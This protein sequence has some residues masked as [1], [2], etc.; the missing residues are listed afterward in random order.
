MSE[1]LDDCKKKVD[2]ILGQKKLTYSVEQLE[3]QISR[4]LHRL[5]LV[6]TDQNQNK[7][8]FKYLLIRNP[9]TEMIFENELKILSEI[10]DQPST[11][12]L[13]NEV[14]DSGLT[15]D[16]WM[17]TNFVEGKV[18]GNT[19][20]FAEE[21]LTEKLLD[22]IVSSTK[23][24]SSLSWS[25]TG[26]ITPKFKLADFE[27]M[28]AY[29]ETV[30]KLA[31]YYPVVK[32][33]LLENLD[34][35]KDKQNYLPAHGDFSP[36][37]ILATGEYFSIIDWESFG[38]N[39]VGFDL[40]YA[41]QRLWRYPKFQKKLETEIFAQLDSKYHKLFWLQILVLLLVDIRTLSRAIEGNNQ[42]VF[43]SK[44]LSDHDFKELLQL[45]LQSFVSTVKEKL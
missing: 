28:V 17:L 16:L 39:L 43:H 31:T 18:I 33:F 6:V 2:L 11:P 1:S 29:I 30:P 3:T 41:Y 42:A 37:N 13:V 24:V 19:Y 32:A 8:I 21:Y 25:G 38:D 14:I 5:V 12:F 34:L 15:P 23:F 26:T 7:Y 36:L 20:E 27:K 22:F 10:A 45:Y 40:A 35:A 9:N 4:K 44:T